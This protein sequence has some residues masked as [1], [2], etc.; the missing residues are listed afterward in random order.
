MDRLYHLLLRRISHDHSINV[1]E[2]FTEQLLAESFLTEFFFSAAKK[3][4][5]AIIFL[6][7]EFG[8]QRSK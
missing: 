3:P 8:K 2:K 6:G 1:R 4:Q 5:K 7:R